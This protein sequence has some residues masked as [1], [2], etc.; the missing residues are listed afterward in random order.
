MF[1][2]SYHLFILSTREYAIV[3]IY[4]NQFLYSIVGE[5]GLFS[6]RD[7]NEEYFYENSV[8]TSFVNT[9]MQFWEST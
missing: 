1:V 6:V 2:C 9:C 5:S 4:H 8:N 7:Y 3:L